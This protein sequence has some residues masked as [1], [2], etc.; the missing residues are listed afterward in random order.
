MLPEMAIFP[1]FLVLQNAAAPV[2]GVPS[3]PATGGPYRSSDEVDQWIASTL[4]FI[5]RMFGSSHYWTEHIF[6]S[7]RFGKVD[8]GR[9]LDK[10]HPKSV[11]A[12]HTTRF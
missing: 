4:G 11:F 8:N 7:S 1:L 2:A 9:L 12:Q 3:A 5:W 10:K 6:S